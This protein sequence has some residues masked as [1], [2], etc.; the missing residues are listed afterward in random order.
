M[1]KI[2]SKMNQ[3]YY[4][5]LIQDIIETNNILNSTVS[6]TVNLTKVSFLNKIK[7]IINLIKGRIK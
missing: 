1:N 7:N 2:K 4:E 5:W 3:K 6:E